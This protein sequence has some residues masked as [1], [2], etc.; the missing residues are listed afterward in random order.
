MEGLRRAGQFR[1]VGTP[2]EL[3]EALSGQASLASPVEGEVGAGDFGV[4]AADCRCRW[5]QSVRVA[6]TPSE[7][8]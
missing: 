2:S 5:S 8:R 1:V 3:R 4:V 6:G 7:L